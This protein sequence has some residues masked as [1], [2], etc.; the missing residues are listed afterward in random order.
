MPPVAAT[1]V[2][3]RECP[4]GYHLRAVAAPGAEDL[5]SGEEVAAASLPVSWVCEKIE[6][7]AANVRYVC[8]PGYPYAMAGQLGTLCYKYV[9]TTPV[10][11]QCPAGYET[12]YV[13]FSVSCRKKSYASMVIEYY[14]DSGWSLSGT[15]CTKKSYTTPTTR[16]EYRCPAGY[17]KSGT[18]C[19]PN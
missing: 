10:N 1:P 15:S 2:T 9:Y 12:I 18:L 14:C 16:I 6:T 17:R 7:K 5:E 3:V 13:G 8:P 19:Y 4:S 11:G